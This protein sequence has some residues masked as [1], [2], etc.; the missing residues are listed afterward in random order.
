MQ[1]HAEWNAEEHLKNE[2]KMLEIFGNA[3]WLLI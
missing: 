3:N 2:G 1:Y